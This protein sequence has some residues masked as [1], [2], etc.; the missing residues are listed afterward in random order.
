MLSAST[1]SKRKSMLQLRAGCAENRS[2]GAR[3]PAL[4]ANELPDISRVNLQKQN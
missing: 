4:F 2:Q 1:M 3:G